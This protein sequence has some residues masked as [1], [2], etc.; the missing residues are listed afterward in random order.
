[1]G[2]RLRIDGDRI[3]GTVR[4]DRRQEGAPGFAHGGAVATV[5]DDALGT[6]LILLRR[7]AV[8]ANLNVDFRAP[9]LL[10]RDLHLEA[11]SEKVDGRKL[12]LA[13]RLSEGPTVI[14]EV[15]ALFVEV[16]LEHFHRGGQPLPD[17]WNAWPE[18]SSRTSAQSPSKR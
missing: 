12:H 8:T 13:G 1:M 6:V 4:F 11:W 3:R 10:E 5:L 7:P 2:L 18:G 15:R 9:A 16:T 14:A 17:A